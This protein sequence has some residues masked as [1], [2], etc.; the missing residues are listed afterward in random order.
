MKS[1]SFKIAL[2]ASLLLHGFFAVLAAFAPELGLWSEDRQRRTVEVELITPDEMLKRMAAAPLGQIVEQNEE[3][4]NDEVPDDAAYLSR[5]DQKVE[6][7]T[8]AALNGKF[9]NA[10]AANGS[11]KPQVQP[12]APKATPKTAQ[13]ADAKKTKGDPNKSTLPIAA[14][15][16]GP[17]KK[18]PLGD[19]KPRFNEYQ[20]DVRAQQEGSGSAQA[21]ATDDHIKKP[22]GLQTL[23]STREFVY[24]SYYNRIKDK[25]RQYWEPK[26]KEKVERIMRQGR[27]I[28]SADRVTKIVILLDR[29]GTLVRVQ[30]IGASGVMDLD[31]AAVEAFRAAA[32]FPNPPKG[33]VEDDGLIRIRWDFILEADASQAWTGEIASNGN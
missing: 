8:R 19:L 15:G 16:D 32:P 28:A 4:L 22:I 31:D 13:E 29:D 6:R 2:V 25:L 5:H 11:A 12:G 7:E 33:I 26:I 21:S 30:V 24:Y 10:Q 27:S 3:R 20:P 18:N 1:R 17:A 23:L 9:V 14:H